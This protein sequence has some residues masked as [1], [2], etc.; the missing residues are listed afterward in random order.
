MEIQACSH[1]VRAHLLHETH[2]RQE[3]EA[4][5]VKRK[6]FINVLINNEFYKSELWPINPLGENGN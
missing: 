5:Q 6:R 2:K 4:H 3:V 1:S